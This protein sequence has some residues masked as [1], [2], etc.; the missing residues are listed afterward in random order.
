MFN[1]NVHLMNTGDSPEH[2]CFWGA[3]DDA[4]QPAK[5]RG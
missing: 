1:W 2:P 4:I 3:M 5:P